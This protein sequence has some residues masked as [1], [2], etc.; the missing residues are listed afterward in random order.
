MESKDGDAIARRDTRSGRDLEFSLGSLE[1]AAVR[2]AGGGG[3]GL[4]VPS[5]SMAGASWFLSFFSNL[6]DSPTR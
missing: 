6:T 3:S 5:E 2:R 4:D 1:A